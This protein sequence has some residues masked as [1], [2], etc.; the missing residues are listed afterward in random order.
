M[1]SQT[2][3][4]FWI[5]LGLAGLL[6]ALYLSDWSGATYPFAHTRRYSNYRAHSGRTTSP[7][8]AE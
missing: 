1:K 6:V 7:K 8:L 2:R 4:G 5:I 3:V